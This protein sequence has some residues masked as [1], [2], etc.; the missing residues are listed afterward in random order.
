M[1]SIKTFI[2]DIKVRSA[3][4][5]VRGMLKL[6]ELK[7]LGS[8]ASTRSYF[9]PSHVLLELITKCN[10]RCQWCRLSE[11]EYR[12]EN[13][14][15][16]DITN[17]LQLLPELHGIKVLMLYGLGEP[18]LY[19]DLE[20]VIREAKRYIPCVCF[21]TNGTLLTEKRS[22]SLA[23]AGLSR[24]HVSIDS[25]DRDLVKRVTG[26]ADIDMII[27][28]IETFSKTTDLPVHL[29]AVV[30]NE[31]IDCLHEIISLKK[32]IPSFNFMHFQLANGATLLNKHGYTSDIPSH[33]MKEFKHMTRRL[34]DENN[35]A[36][37]IGLLPD[38]P[39]PDPRF[40]ICSAPWTGTVMI[41]V[42][43]FLTPCCVLRSYKMANVFEIGLKEAW[44]HKNMRD[45]RK[46]ILNG[47]YNQ[48][49]YNWCRYK[50]V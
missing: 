10:L 21:T 11:K 12:E 14:L 15:Q 47:K 32:R 27:K 50:S 49:C 2:S 22:K 23:E 42:N 13:S 19:P 28:N 46:N 3:Q 29:W 35:I 30:C 25:L 7:V 20:R 26:G 41:N 39:I 37:D 16:I 1:K 9:P 8:K 38:D 44:N 40:G 48:D 34:C 33:Q 6:L 24:I 43:G 31:N 4:R 5:S 45:F 18:L 36:T 17:V